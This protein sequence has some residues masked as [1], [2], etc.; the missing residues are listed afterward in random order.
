MCLT[1]IIISCQQILTI[2]LITIVHSLPFDNNST[3]GRGFSINDLFKEIN[4]ILEHNIQSAIGDSSVEVGDNFTSSNNDGKVQITIE[5]FEYGIDRFPVTFQPDHDDSLE[6]EDKVPLKGDYDEV[7][8]FENNS[9]ESDE[10]ITVPDSIDT[11]T[12]AAEA[13]SVPKTSNSSN[14]EKKLLADAA[15]QPIL[16]TV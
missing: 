2:S 1:K 3:E 8:I 13:K 14:K 9:P 10:E 11:T 7:V 5:K 15:E 4:V 16:T 12:I 6:D